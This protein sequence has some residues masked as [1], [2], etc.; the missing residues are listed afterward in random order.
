[1]NYGDWEYLMNLD[2]NVNEI[3]WAKLFKQICLGIIDLIQS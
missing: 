1:M 2:L 3:N